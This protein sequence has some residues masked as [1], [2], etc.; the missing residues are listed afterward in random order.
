MSDF[1]IPNDLNGIN[2]FVIYPLDECTAK[3]TVIYQASSTTYYELSMKQYQEFV[4]RVRELVD[5]G[6]VIVKPTNRLG[7]LTVRKVTE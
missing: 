2:G 1:L 6:E 5:R 3:L 4:S 7:G